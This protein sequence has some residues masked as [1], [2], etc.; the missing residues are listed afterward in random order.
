MLHNL[1]LKKKILAGGLIPLLFVAMINLL[2]L[3]NFNGVIE[4]YQWVDHTHEVIE[5][6]L[7]IRKTAAD[8]ETGERGYLLTGDEA[9]LEPYE[10]R[11]E[12]FQQMIEELK[13]IVTDKPALQALTRAEEAIVTW[14]KEIAERNIRMRK[15]LKDSPDAAGKMGQ[16]VA[17]GEGKVHFDAFRKEM[18]AFIEREEELLHRRI[19]ESAQITRATNFIIIFGTVAALLLAAVISFAMIK[20]ITV[21]IGII[22]EAAMKISLGETDVAIEVESRDELADLANAFKGMIKNLNDTSAIAHQIGQGDLNVTVSKRSEKDVLGN[23]LEN[24]IKNLNT[25]MAELKE[26]TMVLSSAAGEILATTA[27]VS[28]SANQTSAAVS[29]TSAS[30]EE[31]K[32]T[33]KVSSAKAVHTSESTNKTM[34]IARSG[35]EALGQNMDGLTQIKEKMDLIAANIIQLSEQSQMI[36]EIVSTVEDIANQ[37]NLLAVNASIEAVKAG[38]HGKGFSVVAQELKNLADQSKQGTRQVQKILSDIQQSTGTLVMVAEQGGKAVE[39]GVGQA[40]N[41]KNS[42]DVLNTSILEAA[43]AGKQ[44]AASYEQELAGMDQIASA[45]GSIKEATA[46]NVSSIRQVE[47]S[48]KNLNTLGQKLKLLM[49]QYSIAEIKR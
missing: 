12:M 47:E 14:K 15:E 1:S 17:K 23:A 18:R 21:P 37:S 3:Y 8:M 45:M 25:I 41:A 33:A 20:I 24:M 26:S 6:G 11:K 42:M 19:K 36:S 31:I 30:V 13:P 28:S 7:E 38:E 49:D 29:Q 2:G 46:Q 27:Q 48:A 39:S 43:K 10:Y 22:K 40:R 16:L 35:A 9:F 5:K 44:I 34:E 4:S 32:Q